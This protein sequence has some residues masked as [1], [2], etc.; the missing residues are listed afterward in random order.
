MG[1][2]SAMAFILLLIILVI[3]LVQIRLGRSKWEY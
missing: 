2:A 1:Y 3:T